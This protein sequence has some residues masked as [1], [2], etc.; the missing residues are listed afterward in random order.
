ME[1][2]GIIIT[3]IV[4]LALAY[5]MKHDEEDDDERMIR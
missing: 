5:C 1:L 4:M 3:L 2:S